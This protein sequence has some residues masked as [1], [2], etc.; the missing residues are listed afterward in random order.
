MR[1]RR[2]SCIL[3]AMSE[4]PSQSW[5][6]QGGKGYVLTKEDGVAAL[7]IEGFLPGEKGTREVRAVMGQIAQ[8]MR[9]ISRNRE[10]ALKIAIPESLRL[11]VVRGREI[12]MHATA[13]NRILL[14]F[15]D[16]STQD[17]S[18]LILLPGQSAF[19]RVEGRF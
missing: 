11:R 16:E 15:R 12:E 19:R 6:K 17:K 7:L 5:T 1:Q 3:L 8:E 10:V 14:L 13:D 18:S 9:S 2:T 4:A